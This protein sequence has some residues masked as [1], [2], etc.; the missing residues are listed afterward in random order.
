[1]DPTD[2]C[3]CGST[4]RETKEREDIERERGRRD[5]LGAVFDLCVSS[6][7]PVFL[8]SLAAAAAGAGAGAAGATAGAG[9]SKKSGAGEAKAGEGG[10]ELVVVSASCTGGGAREPAT[11]VSVL[12]LLASAR[13]QSDG[14][15]AAAGAR[16]LLVTLTLHPEFCVPRVREA[17]EARRAL[18][19]LR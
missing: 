13:A 8:T 14:P 9:A 10:D 5:H 11:D 18:G 12:A 2:P 16:G 7:S 6:A 4:Y 1:M 19:A 17:A 3:V 15:T